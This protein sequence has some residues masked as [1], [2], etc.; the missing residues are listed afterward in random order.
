VTFRIS[1]SSSCVSNAVA[2]THSWMRVSS[3]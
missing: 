3:F 1:C 2:I